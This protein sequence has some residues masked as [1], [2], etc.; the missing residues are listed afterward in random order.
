MTEQK[1]DQALHRWLRLPTIVCVGCI[2]LGILS[3][4]LPSDCDDGV[5]DDAYMFIRYAD[6][7]LERGKLS[8]NPGGEP[9]YGLT[10]NL[11]LACVLVVR[12]L[13]GE[14]ATLAAAISSLVCGVFFLAAL[15]FLLYGFVE[16]SPL[17]RRTAVLFVL[18][19][20][21]MSV[22]EWGKHFVSG[23]DTTF[24]LAYLSTFIII[25]KWHARSPKWSSATLMGVLGGLAF[26]ARPDLMAFTIAVP[27]AI[28]LLSGDKK[29]KYLGAAA[30][31]IAVLLTGV[32]V[33][34]AGVYF[35]SPL[36]LPFYMKG[37]ERYGESIHQQ[38]R[39]VPFVQL[40]RYALSLRYLL[41]L[42]ATGAIVNFRRWWKNGPATEIGLGV[43][44]CAFILYYLFFVHQIMYYHQR[45]YYPTFP[46]IALL[47]SQSGAGLIERLTRSCAGH[48]Q[49]IPAWLPKLASVFVCVAL[50][51][52]LFS[53][54][55]EVAA[56]LY[57]GDYSRYYLLEDYKARWAH[58]WYRLDRFSSL[59][60]SLVIATTEV[61]RPAAMNPRKTIV[62][63]SGLNETDFAH[64]GFS[65]DLLFENYEP[66]L[67]YMP[68][69]HYADMSKQILEHPYFKE[70]Y[71]YFTTEMLERA[72]MGVAIRRDSIHYHALR[73]ILPVPSVR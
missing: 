70:K 7:L 42:I 17:A 41:F 29:A 9:T 5:W 2:V 43:G 37:L 52:S 13:L 64:S 48:L 68:H 49:R 15:A 28:I 56:G 50:L 69:P 55:R 71:E 62:D 27:V 51:S 6:N 22:D 38:Y 19:T 26:S 34:L 33:L 36:P 59:P 23:M 3:E 21:A 1:K 44:A 39:T 60:D 54:A 14:N 65:A 53:P 35:G 61:G 31:L 73:R 18:C 20:L 32:Q 66:D 24:A 72:R 57:R 40:Y 45:F 47:A 11:Y 25:S 58:Y 67:V 12:L 46:A 63:L 8:W 4:F 16:G 10:S 30:L